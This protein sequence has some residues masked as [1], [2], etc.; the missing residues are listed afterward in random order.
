MARIGVDNILPDDAL[1]PFLISIYPPSHNKDNGCSVELNFVSSQV[2]STA[3]SR[4]SSS[5]RADLELLGNWLHKCLTNHKRCRQDDQVWFPTRLLYLGSQAG[6]VRLIIT[7]ENP[8]DG[9]YITLSHR[10]TNQKYKKLESS[11]IAQ[12][13][14]TVN[15]IHLPQV[16]QDT[17]KIARHLG[18]HYLWIDS[19]CIKQDKDNITDWLKESKMMDRIYGFAHLNISATWSVKAGDRLL[20][21]SSWASK[22]PSQIEIDFEHVSRKYFVIDG[23]LWDNEVD[24]GPLNDRGWVFQERY[25]ARR[26]AHFG[27]SQLAWECRE[28]RALE[29]FPGGLPQSL[30][31]SATKHECATATTEPTSRS[32]KLQVSKF[33]IEWQRLLDDYSGCELEFRRDKLIA[34]EGI[35]RRI[36]TSRP[37]DTYL[38]GLWKSTALY[39]LPW[40]RNEYDREQFPIAKTCD[41]APSWSWASVDGHIVFPLAD[42]FFPEV[43]EC[44]A[45]V[46]GLS[47]H[48]RA[49]SNEVLTTGTIQLE[50]IC[51][52]LSLQWSEDNDIIGFSVPGFQFSTTKGLLKSTIY[53]ECATEVS[54]A[55]SSSRKLLF[56][57]LFTMTRSIY[58]IVLQKV[59]GLSEHRRIGA[60]HIALMTTTEIALEDRHDR[61]ILERKQQPQIVAHCDAMKKFIEKWSR[62]ALMFILYLKK[63]KPPFRHVNIS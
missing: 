42:D 7:S 39:D 25:L 2:H 35:A 53:F 34:L 11:T 5:S 43:H 38:A 61:N 6:D 20:G 51:L 9:P 22:L 54:Y 57:P 18:I 12:L 30:G 58:G 27:E 41:R 16:F 63:R 33:A 10:W 45:D 40:H 50:G 15:V 37:G 1:P 21:K 55:L 56:M 24:N 14:Q 36:M 52:P 4:R 29:M 28:W 60:V 44:H 8:P 13:Q 23:S 31:V 26:V 62:P 32:T 17:I 49:M 48:S 3:L 19:L 47:G 59:Y 46:K